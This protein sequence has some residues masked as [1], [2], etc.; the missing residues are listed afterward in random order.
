MFEFLPY[1]LQHILTKYGT[2]Y[3]SPWRARCRLHWKIERILHEYLETRTMAVRSRVLGV[4]KYRYLLHIQFTCHENGRGNAA[5]RHLGE[6][7]NRHLVER[8][9]HHLVERSNRHIVERSN[10]NL[11]ERSY[12][13]L[14]KRS[15]HHLV[16]R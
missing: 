6:R 5:V 8:S 3:C 7:S 16:K 4:T 11:V 2:C 15:Y 9:N 14:V 10:R 12:C 13:H 1:K